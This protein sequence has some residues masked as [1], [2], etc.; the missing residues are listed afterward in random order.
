M[1]QALRSIH[2]GLH[3]S[4]Q[5]A[6]RRR[7]P[8]Q[9]GLAIRF[10]G[11][12]GINRAGQCRVVAAF[13]GEGRLADL[14]RVGDGDR[15]VRIVVQRHALLAVRHRIAF[16]RRFFDG[17]GHHMAVFVPAAQRKGLAC[18]VLFAVGRQFN[19]LARQ[20]AVLF[21]GSLNRYLP[22]LFFVQA[23]HIDKPLRDG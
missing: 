16:W 3:L 1:G 23:A 20:R 2:N 9:I 15:L 12:H 13:F 21:A 14:T 18:L 17:I 7:P 22:R 4:R 11:Q 10:P 8:D 5:H 19:R 6:V